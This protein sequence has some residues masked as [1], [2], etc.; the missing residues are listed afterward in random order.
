MTRLG[1]RR[2]G[3]LAVVMLGVT[4]TFA[5]SAARGADAQETTGRVAS[6]SAAGDAIGLF[7]TFDQENLLPLS[8]VLAT[9]GPRAQVIVDSLPR[10]FARGTPFDP[11]VLATVGGATGLAL[12]AVPFA[13]L[14]P[15]LAGAYEQFKKDVLK[16]ALPENPVPPWPFFAD[17]AT[18][19][20]DPAAT[21]GFGPAFYGKALTTGGEGDL[22]GS[23]LSSSAATAEAGLAA[24]QLP[25]SDGGPIGGPPRSRPGQ[26]GG[27][28][29]SERE[30]HVVR[31]SGVTSGSQGSG[32]ESTRAESVVKIADVSLLN[33]YI[34]LRGVRSFAAATA[35]GKP[36]ASFDVDQV[37]VA[38]SAA[39][40]T[41]QGVRLLDPG[42][43]G[44]Q[45]QAQINDFLK[46]IGFEI[47]LVQK[48]SAADRQSVAALA[49]RFAR[50]LLPADIP[51]VIAAG[52]DR[53]TLDIGYVSAAASVTR[54]QTFSSSADASDAQT[55]VGSAGPGD[56]ATGGSGAGASGSWTFD[57]ASSSSVAA[58]DS[59]A[60]GSPSETTGV[61]SGV[62]QWVESAA[63]P[64]DVM[65]AGEVT[66]LASASPTGGPG[67]A[68]LP[69]SV[70]DAGFF[71]DRDLRGSM[72]PVGV[73]GL[74]GAFALH[75]LVRRIRVLKV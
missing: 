23:S 53:V 3:V 49:V 72:L 24:I 51:G 74:S 54:V 56:D 13:N 8:P 61:N 15:G 31:L 37:T 66:G 9:G 62:V 44:A 58:P 22:S 35:D 36:V 38:G 17:S 39:R 42:Q 75:R 25:G 64:D 50:Q 45:S 46:K 59:M 7:F 30:P 40:L 29:G 21:A 41:E 73:V 5:V 10:V 55:S 47:H 28:E 57:D 33:G 27:V 34:H 65:G 1:V 32:G 52:E 14:V 18:P 12:G 60:A 26:D 6:F 4:G 20:G 67:G 63:R 43:P 68:K 71:T 16:P 2:A 19:G 48:V 70:S 11:G 69:L